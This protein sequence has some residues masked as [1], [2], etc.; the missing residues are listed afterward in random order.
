[1]KVCLVDFTYYISKGILCPR[2]NVICQASEVF[3]L[4]GQVQSCLKCALGRQ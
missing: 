4:V 2:S 3:S 1:V